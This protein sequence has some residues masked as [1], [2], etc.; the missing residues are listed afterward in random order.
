M[1][2]ARTGEAAPERWTGPVYQDFNLLRAA[3]LAGQ[4][5]AL[6]PR[7]MIGDDLAAG[8]LCQLSDVAVLEAS[9]YYLLRGPMAARRGAAAT[10]FRDWARAEA[11]G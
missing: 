9:G 4:G 10:A 5:A 3:A 11:Q 2:F 8:R 6:C 7:A 1:W